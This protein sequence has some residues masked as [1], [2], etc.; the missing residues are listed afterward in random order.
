MATKSNT[1]YNSRYEDIVDDIK[2]E[3]FEKLQEY[4]DNAGDYVA[5]YETKIDSKEA[6]LRAVQ[7][8]V[9]DIDNIYNTYDKKAKNYKKDGNIDTETYD[10][11]KINL[12]DT[13]KKY[14]TVLANILQ[15]DNNAIKEDIIRERLEE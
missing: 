6:L 7:N 12:A 1:N 8:Y 14:K 5:E 15:G 3:Y 2:E 9:K 11:L 13:L 4:I 10:K